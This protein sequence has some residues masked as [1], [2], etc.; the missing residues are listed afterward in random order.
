MNGYIF[1]TQTTDFKNINDLNIFYTETTTFQKH[2]WLHIFTQT[3]A[4]L[5]HQWFKHFLHTLLPFK[6]INYYTF[7]TQTTTFLM[8]IRFLQKLLP[9]KNIN[10]YTNHYLSKTWMITHFLHRLLPY[11]I[12]KLVLTENLR[13]L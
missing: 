6:N 11:L 2:E 9:F 3:T 7:F 12:T 13:F 5:K 4:F 1:F 8:I 10:D